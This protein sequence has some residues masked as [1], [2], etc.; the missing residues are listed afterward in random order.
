MELIDKIK[1]YDS[2]H[3]FLWLIKDTCWMLELKW[4]GSIMI[5]P[6]VSLATYL[7]YKTRSSA[8]LFLNT[9]V[10]FW[11]VANSYWMLMEFFNNDLHK[12][13]AVIPFLLGF[14]CIGVYYWKRPNTAKVTS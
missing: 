1:K 6:A 3:I 13:Y 12:H 2:I 7:I 14:V 5:V 11:I 8:E 4:L 10:F 9:S